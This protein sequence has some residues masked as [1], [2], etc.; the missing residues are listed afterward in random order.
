MK[1]RIDHSTCAGCGLC[2]NTAPSLFYINGFY[3][4]TF[5]D[6]EQQLEQDELLRCRLLEI[7]QICPAGALVLEY[8]EGEE[9]LSD[10]G[11]SAEI[12]HFHQPKSSSGK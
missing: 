12:L 8:D 1:I 7:L 5:S 2:R 3:A 10:N 6:S 11:C 4:E 9:H